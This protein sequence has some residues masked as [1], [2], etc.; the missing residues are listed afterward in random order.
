MKSTRGEAN[1][2]RAQRK[3]RNCMRARKYQVD[4]IYY[5]KRRKKN[6]QKRAENK[7]RKKL[8]LEFVERL[9]IDSL[10]SLSLSLSRFSSSTRSAAGFFFAY[11]YT[12]TF[13]R[14]EF[15]SY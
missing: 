13:A 8:I 14:Q 6:K 9:F 7:R 10:R 12:N 5:F 11:N 2:E 4:I 15:T 1:R 3:V